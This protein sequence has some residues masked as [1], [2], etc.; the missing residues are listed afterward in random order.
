MYFVYLVTALIISFHLFNVAKGKAPLFR[1]SFLD[2]P[3]LLFLFSQT[4]S[5]FFSVDVHTSIFGYYSRLNG[6]LISVIS[7]LCLYWILVVYQSDR[8]KTNLINASLISGFFVATYGIL[9]H[10]GIDKNW[11]VQD[12]QQ[13]VFSTLGQPNWLA[14]YLCILL[15][16]SIYKSINSKRPYLYSSLTVILFLCL[17]F[18]KSKSGIIAGI[19]SIGIYLI[20]TFFQNKSSQKLIVILSLLF[21]IFGLSIDNPIKDRFFSPKP[22]LAP[23]RSDINITPSE[24]IRKIVWQGAFD[25]WRQFP[26][27]GTGTETFAYSYYWVRPASHNLTSEWDFL[28]NKAHNEYI[29]YLA[30]TGTVGFITYLL[31]ILVI[32]AKFKNPYSLPILTSFIS[33][34]ITNFAGFSVVITSVY[35][36]LMPAFLATPSPP[37]TPNF[38]RFLKAPL[39]ILTIIFTFISIKTI[40]SFY[41]ADIYFASA[42]TSNSRQLYTDSYNSIQSSL[43][44]RPNE[45]EYLIFAS[46]VAAKLALASKD[47]SPTFINRAIELANKAT[48]ISPSNTNLWKEKSQ[49]YY[50]LASFDPKYYL[51]SINSLITVTKLAPTDAKTF[52]LIG[53]FLEN[54]KSIPD[55]I[56]YYQKAIALKANYDHAYFAL[57]KI[58]F[59][60]KQYTDA[61]FNFEQV[62]KYA[63]TSTE[64]KDY[65]EK[66]SKVL[67]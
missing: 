10:F 65:L 17:L 43:A 3:L 8:L 19:I 14:A 7:Y 9:E 67:P 4:L 64:T 33:I 42:S 44:L 6:G 58:Y 47:N 1:R 2:L 20:F 41:L 50:Y 36:F 12:V 48:E 27:F 62:L 26:V 28:Y 5:T 38:N 11:W 59:D 63:P 13:R 66:I 61:K 24:D 45:P 25:L 22:D 46:S 16:F 60:Q 53:Q 37:S 56:T 15:P 40:I 29:N 49:T 54:A 30:T 34:L 57:G 35:F 18:T 32:V 51:T 21:T 55:A 23:L 31:I 39:I 52:Y